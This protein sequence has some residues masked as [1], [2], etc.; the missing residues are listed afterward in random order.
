MEEHTCNCI[1]VVVAFRGIVVTHFATLGVVVPLQYSEGC[2]TCTHSVV[3][4]QRESCSIVVALGGIVVAL[5][6]H[7]R[8]M[9]VARADQM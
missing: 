3:A 9:V 2:S 7:S 6:Y 1:V 4:L 8:G 5:L